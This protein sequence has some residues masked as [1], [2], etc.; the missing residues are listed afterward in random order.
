MDVNRHESSK[1]LQGG[2]TATVRG[3]DIFVSKHHSRI[4]NGV[5]VRELGPSESVGNIARTGDGWRVMIYA[6]VYPERFHH[7]DVAQAYALSLL[8]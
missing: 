2:G 6:H 3:T 7:I 4:E 8:T 5:V 1:P